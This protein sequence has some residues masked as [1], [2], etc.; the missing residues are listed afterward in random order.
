MFQNKNLPKMYWKKLE[1]ESCT[2]NNNPLREIK[3]ITNNYDSGDNDN[4]TEKN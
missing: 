2:S 4:E 3:D 1:V